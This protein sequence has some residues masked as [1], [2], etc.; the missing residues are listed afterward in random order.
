MAFWWV[1]PGQTYE[2]ERAGGYLWAPKRVKNGTRRRFYDA[3]RDA[4][5]MI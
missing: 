4:R 2:Q 3:M 1:N 5:S